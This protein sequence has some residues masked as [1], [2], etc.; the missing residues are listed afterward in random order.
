M[1]RQRCAVRGI[2]R[3]IISVL[4]FGITRLQLVQVAAKRSAV[5]CILFFEIPP[6]VQAS[7]KN[8]YY[9][10]FYFSSCR[11]S[12]QIEEITIYL[13]LSEVGMQSTIYY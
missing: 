3:Q 8:A 7:E 5:R 11:Q 1:V 4:L 2:D 10:N 12:P 13:S 6:R 9:L